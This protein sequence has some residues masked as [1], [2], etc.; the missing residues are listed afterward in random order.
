VDIGQARQA[1]DAA[2][3]ANAAE[4]YPDDYAALEKR[5][6][7]ARGVFYACRDDEASRL[8]KALIADANALAARRAEA[9]PPPPPPANRPP[10]ARLQGPA[11][12]EINA[13]LAFSGEGSSDPDRD[14]LTYSWD[15]GDGTTA[16]FTFPNATHRYARIGNYTVRLTVSDGRGGS[17]TATKALVIVKRE[18]IHGDV[19]FD[20]DKSVLKPAAERTLAGIVQQMKSEPTLRADVVGHTDWIG[21]DE[22]NMGLSKRRAEAVRNHLVAKG[23]AANRLSVS[24]KGESQ[25][26][27]SNATPEGRAKNRRVEITL[28]PPAP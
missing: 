25:P 7:E 10:S 9:P 21:T 13:L 2:K 11:E 19:L 18:V 8:A 6:L 22:Y 23:I 1:L 17:D 26:I 12:G 16:S 20:F 14:P 3:K 24:W 4:R 27:A 28:R 15:F 5:Y